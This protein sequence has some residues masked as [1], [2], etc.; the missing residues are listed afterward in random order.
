MKGLFTGAF[1]A[2]LAIVSMKGA[3]N[4]GYKKG[5]KDGFEV[6]DFMREVKEHIKNKK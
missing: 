2:V 1:C 3:Y 4:K 5:L 6:N